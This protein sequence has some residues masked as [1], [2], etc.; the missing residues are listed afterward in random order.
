MNRRVVGALLLLLVGAVAIVAAWFLLP[1]FKEIQEKAATDAQDT[2]GKISLVLDNWTGYFIFRSAEMKKQL[3]R[4]G[5]L[6]SCEDDNADY[7]RRMKRLRDGEID[8]AVATVDSFVVDTAGF[9]VPG[10]IIMVIDESKGGDAILARSDKVTSLDDL[11]GRPNI[12]VSFTPDSPSHYLLKAASHHFHV[13]EL[14]PPPG[15]LRIETKGSTEALAKL[16]QGNTDVAVMW[17]PDVSRAL[18]QQGIVKIL[19]TEDTEKL[20]VDILL[21]N[22]R[23]AQ[24]NPDVVK[25]VLSAY[26]GV[27]KEF[28]QQPQLLRERLVAETGLPEGS[29]DSML[30]G[31]RW[32][33]LTENCEQWFGIAGPGIS[34]QEVLVNTIESTISTLIHAGD[35]STNPVPSGDAYRLINSSYLKD[36]FVKGITGFKSPGKGEPPA[37]AKSSLQARFTSLDE[38][39]W[40][41]LREVGTLRVDPVIFQSGSHQLDFMAKEVID[42]AVDILKHYPHFRMVVKGHTGTAG[43]PALNQRLSQERAE[44]VTRYLEVTHNIDPKRM[45][46]EG[47]GGAVPLPRKPDESVRAWEYKLPRVEIVLVRDEL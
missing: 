16:L 27:L 35:F 42:Q 12:A 15:P 13:P 2:K 21:V 23:F 20:I 24:K 11:K 39:G 17:E 37:D 7:T 30:K 45:K 47:Y 3:R 8:F 26:F 22:R 25:L 43:D 34:G 31:V 41:A 6:L 4:A 32:V 1:L 9:G 18:S 44:A 5:W 29:V 46:A 40:L 36:L 38:G 28:Q 19:G 10:T 14:L 33:N